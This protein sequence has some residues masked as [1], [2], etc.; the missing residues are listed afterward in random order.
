MVRCT[1]LLELCVISKSVVANRM[2]GENI[3]Q[4]R[5]VQNEQNR[6]QKRALRYTI[7]NKRRI[8]MLMILYVS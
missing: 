1:C 2:T 7:L 6:P 8:E 4:W 3:I 5:H